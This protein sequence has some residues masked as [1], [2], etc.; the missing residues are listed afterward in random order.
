MSLDKKT[1]ATLAEFDS[2][3][4]SNVIELFDVVPRNRGY[5]NGE[6]QA[7]FPDLPPMVGFAATAGFRS[8]A[9]PA[10]DDVYAG[11][12][13]QVDSFAELPGS[14]VPVFLSVRGWS[15]DARPSSGSHPTSK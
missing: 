1:L 7:H 2:A 15:V 13:R 11:L 8:H 4:I 5:M 14:A 10:G 9:P 6:I 3:T 12:L